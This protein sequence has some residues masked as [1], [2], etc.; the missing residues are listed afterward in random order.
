MLDLDETNAGPADHNLTVEFKFETHAVR[1]ITKDGEPW[2]VAAD[3]CA[4]LEHSNS[5]KA[6]E[7]LDPD[8]RG[9]I[10]VYTPGG[11]QD[12][13]VVNE[14][15]LYSLIFMSRLPKAKE[16]RRWVTHEDLPAIRKTGRYDARASQTPHI[17]DAHNPGAAYLALALMAISSQWFNN[18]R[19]ASKRNAG[20]LSLDEDDAAVRA[21][22][23]AIRHG[24]RLAHAL[25]HAHS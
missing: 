15:G 1:T 20:V 24:E 3:V 13:N 2:F 12:M 4:V 19:L 5:R 16:F 21:L 6:I 11:P 18:L 7:P 9:V 25:L 17:E 23:D 14:F 22:A 8:E 10:N